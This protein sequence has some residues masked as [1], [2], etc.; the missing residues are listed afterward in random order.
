MYRTAGR[1]GYSEWE[2]ELDAPTTLRI[3]AVVAKADPGDQRFQLA[4]GK[5]P[6]HELTADWRG[7]FGGAAL[8]AFAFVVGSVTFIVTWMLRHGGATRRDG[9]R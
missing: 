6:V 2:F 3:E 9:S 4:V 5:M 1:E 8:L 7:V